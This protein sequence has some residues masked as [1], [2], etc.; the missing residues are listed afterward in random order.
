MNNYKIKTMK[1]G[2]V[3]KIPFWTIEETYK[4]WVR[5]IR[6]YK[7]TELY[8]QRALLEEARK[9]SSLIHANDWIDHDYYEKLVEQSYEKNARIIA[10]YGPKFKKP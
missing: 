2:K 3:K 8:P 5:V 1:T 6:K 4:V 9:A 10:K 7:L